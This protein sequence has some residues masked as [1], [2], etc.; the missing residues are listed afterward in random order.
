M[1]MRYWAFGNLYLLALLTICRFVFW[2]FNGS[3]TPGLIFEETLMAFVVGLRFDLMVLGFFNF[4]LLLI[5]WS[6]RI[7]K[8]LKYYF[9]FM[10]AVVSVISYMDLIYYQQ[11]QDRL[12][13][14]FLFPHSQPG[15]D[16][17][18]RQLSFSIATFV[19]AMIYIL[20]ILKWKCSAGT[21]RPRNYFLI[22]LLISLAARGSLGSHHLDLRHSN[23]SEN[24]FINLLCIN[25]PY[26]L[27]QALRGRR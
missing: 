26:A 20:F 24:N 8:Q 13:R 15:W 22:F 10:A 6:P 3:S 14:L 27:D 19:P 12:N 9:V 23:I 25:S 11:N 7:T 5:L 18:L 17:L 21:V 4:P 16:V 1:S 2:L